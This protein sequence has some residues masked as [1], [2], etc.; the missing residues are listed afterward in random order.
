MAI[1]R[2]LPFISISPCPTF[3]FKQWGIP[4][5]SICCH[6]P[7]EKQIIF[8]TQNVGVRCVLAGPIQYSFLHTHMHTLFPELEKNMI[9]GN[10][11][12]K[13]YFS[14]WFINIWLW[15]CYSN[16]AKEWQKDNKDSWLWRSRD[17][18][19]MSIWASQRY[20]YKQKEILFKN[21]WSGK[22]S[23]NIHASNHIPPNI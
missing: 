15:N 22:T 17:S 14:G 9:L 20:N 23:M 8:S 11:Q 13:C 21:Y 18:M 12:K 4:G 6:L 2:S 16:R 19:T 10:R 5:A 7:L 1:C 3:P